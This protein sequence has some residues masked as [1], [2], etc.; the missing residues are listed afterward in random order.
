MPSS[1]LPLAGLWLYISLSLL[2]LVG[3]GL[4]SLSSLFSV[5]GSGLQI[6]SCVVLIVCL[7][8]QFS[9]CITSSDGSCLLLLSSLSFGQ[10]VAEKKSRLGGRGWGASNLRKTLNQTELGRISINSCNR[11]HRAKRLRDLIGKVTCHCNWKVRKPVLGR[12]WP[13]VRDK[14]VPWAIQYEFFEF[15]IRSLVHCLSF[16]DLLLFFGVGPARH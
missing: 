7:Q 10:L 6:F 15:L 11:F 14:G 13:V 3:P 8:V 12:V 4:Q 2:P 5:L 1:L 16:K 9:S